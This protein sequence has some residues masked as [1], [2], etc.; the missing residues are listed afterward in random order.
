MRASSSRLSYPGY[1]QRRYQF[2]VFLLRSYGDPKTA[3]A[4]FD[5]APVA[6]DDPVLA[7]GIHK[8][9]GI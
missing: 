2:P 1:L 3:L 9:A 4:Q 7:A 6:H 5:F 8:T